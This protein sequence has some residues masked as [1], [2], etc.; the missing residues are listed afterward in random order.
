MATARLRETRSHPAIQLV[1][2]WQIPPGPDQQPEQRVTDSQRTELIRLHA[3]S[4]RPAPCDSA[5]A[6]TASRRARKP[7][8]GSV[9]TASVSSS[10]ATNLD[11]ATA[12]RR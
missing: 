11:F 4:N 7:C 10:A 3:P 12:P 2:G 6:K 8:S 5:D 9:Q 1:F